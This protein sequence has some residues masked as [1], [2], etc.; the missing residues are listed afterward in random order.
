MV[1]GAAI[2]DNLLFS[3]LSKETSYS[4][5]LFIL[6]H[7]CIGNRFEYK[8]SMISRETINLK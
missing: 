1:I 3:R 5:A 2:T 6:F 7:V 8:R 4:F